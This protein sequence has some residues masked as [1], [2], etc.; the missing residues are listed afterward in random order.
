MRCGILLLNWNA[1]R[2]TV[3]C[4]ESLFRSDLEGHTVIVCDNGSEDGSLERLQAWADGHLDVPVSGSPITPSA[5]V[6]PRPIEWRELSRDEAETGAHR[7]A[8]EDDRQEPPL[9]FIRNGENL[10]YAGGCNVGL[11]YIL[12]CTELD[13]VWLLNNDAVVRPDSLR[14]L[15]REIE[16]DPA[17]GIC[18]SVVLHYDAPGVVQA[19]AGGSY[20]PWLALPRMVGA[21][22]PAGRLLPADRVRQRLDYVTGASMLV[23]R[24]FLE[25]VGL[26]SEDYFLYFEELDWAL[27]ARGRFLLGYAAGSLVYHK[28]G[29][30]AGT[31]GARI[32]SDLADHYFMRNRIRVTRRFFPRALPTVRLALL[33]AAG[34]RASRGQWDRARMILRMIRD[35]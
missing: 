2:D 29:R 27:R 6:V 20:Q 17:I 33:M 11:R 7:D 23:R 9:L 30:S 22:R 15:L 10:G 35:E 14:H 3:E 16:R 34:R 4:L 31:R 8:T 19:L 5:G 32:K 25:E 13:A 24:R 12:R 1:W 28:E 18:G 21:G 26:M